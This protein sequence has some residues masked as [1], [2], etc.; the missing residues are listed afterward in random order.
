[1]ATYRLCYKKGKVGYSKNHAAYIQREDGY[2]S[3]E[4]DLVYTESGNM[5][6]NGET[7][8]AKKFWEY[9]DTYERTNSV[10]YRELEL[11][12]P[13]EFNH[14]QA[15]ELINNFVKKE[16]GEKYPYTYAIHEAKNEKD[17]KNL[18]CHLMFSERELDGIDRE[19]SQYFKRANSKNPEK[20]GAKKN[21]EW[22][23]KSRLLDLRKSWEIETNNLLEKN[24]FEARVDCRTLKEIRQDLLESGMFDKAET[25][26]R[27]PINVAGKIL[28]KVGHGIELNGEEKQQYD[29]YIETVNRK[30][31]LERIYQERENKKIEHKNLKA[32]IEKLE[33]EN[34]K[35][36]AINICSKGQYFKTKKQY[37]DISKKVKKYPENIILKKEQERLAKTIKEI[38]DKS[39]KSNK[40]INIFANLETKRVSTLESLKAEYFEKFKDKY[41]TKDEEKIKEKYQDYDMLKLKIK[42]E[43]LSNENPTEKAINVLTNYEYN[44]KFVEAFEIQENKK[45]IESKYN[46]AALFNPRQAKDFKLALSIEEKNIEN[47]QDEII[48]LIDNVDEKKLNDLAEKIEKNT[49]IEKTIIIELI[50]EKV[51]SRNEVDLMKDKV[52]LLDKFSNLEKLYNKEIA[53]DEKNKKKIFSISSELASIES[54]LNS[55]Y[56][57][58]DIKGDIA[59][60]NLKV[61]QEQIAKNDKRILMAENVIDKTKTIISAH[62]KKYNLSGIE[63]IAIGNLSKGKYWRNY[64]EMKKLTSEIKKDEKI[65]SNMGI[66]SFGKGVLK[67]NIELKKKKLEDLEKKEKKIV[68]TYK[69]NKSF[70]SEVGKVNSH[71]N[72]ILKTYQSILVTAKMDNKINYKIKFTVEKHGKEITTY[73]KNPSKN[74]SKSVVIEGTRGLKSNVKSIFDDTEVRATVG[75]HLEKDKENGWEI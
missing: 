2:Q 3:K 74:K 65:L 70:S 46:E 54:L 39:I 63:V 36:K 21:R 41:L 12:I 48:K 6:F 1:M 32:E 67:K 75:I 42:L 31:E 44:L 62:S 22:Q 33:K 53:S 26:N 59:Q 18:H 30:K 52:I 50:K 27:L 40:Y 10:A 19:L 69:Q 16:I 29:K 15:K 47:K 4:E 45:N 13:N 23:E 49:K 24:G 68:N 11:T 60:N 71:Y 58:I 37:Y 51:Q 56:K 35:E 5:N 55:E 17:E 9:A 66:V 14:E 43:T 72:S 20:G 61:I 34:S 73:K 57:S 8:S 7:I 64:K 25:Y 38:E 28:Y